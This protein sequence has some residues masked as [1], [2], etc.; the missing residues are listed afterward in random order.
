[1]KITT[2][3]L[4]KAMDFK[5]DKKIVG[6]TSGAF[7]IVHA[8]HVQLLREARK[9]CDILIVGLNSDAS[10]KRY[11]SA[12]RPINTEHD[13][14]SVMSAFEYI[15]YIFVFD[16]NNNN[17][18]IEELKPDLYI[19]GE[20]YKNKPLSSSALLE[21]YGGKT[22]LIN[23][24][25][26]RS[27]S[28]IVDVIIS[29][30]LSTKLSED[31]I[32]DGIAFID[33]DGVINED[34]GY[35]H[36]EEDFTLIAG[37]VEAIKILNNKNIAVVVV[38]NQPGIGVGLYSDLDFTKI[39]I[40]MI[41]ELHKMGARLDKIYYCPDMIAASKYKKPNGGM[42]VKALSEIKITRDAKKY[43]FGDSRSDSLAAK[44]ADPSIVTVGLLTGRGL[45]DNWVDHNPDMTYNTLLEAVEKVVV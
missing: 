42:L 22:V 34:V 27:T 2:R 45:K 31:H 5:K 37:T 14:L 17:K 29:K 36:K 38:T 11:K 1:M 13:R 18:N 19:K 8:G 23:L 9:L 28:N 33:R 25:Q 10:I 24:A 41:K 6:F 4:I 40:I 15:D 43:M 39:N 7:D 21:Q 26:G 32:Y 12:N 35:L 44:N 30:E 3:D 20:D 16:E